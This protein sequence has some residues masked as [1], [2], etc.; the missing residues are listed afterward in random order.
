MVQA[1]CQIDN[2]CAWYRSGRI[3]SYGR[4]AAG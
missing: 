3:D 2:M 4:N 1:Q